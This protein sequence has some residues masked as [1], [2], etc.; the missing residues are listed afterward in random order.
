MRREQIVQHNQ[1]ISI[2]YLVIVNSVNTTKCKTNKEVER[3]QIC[4]NCFKLHF[5]AWITK[6][7]LLFP[8]NKQPFA[9][10]RDCRHNGILHHL[11]TLLIR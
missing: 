8:R 3:N 10:C 5:A 6:K 9:I 4:V 2:L 11:S 1:D 7:S